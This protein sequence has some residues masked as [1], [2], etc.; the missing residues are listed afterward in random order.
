MAGFCARAEADDY[1]QWGKSALIYLKTSP[2]GANVTG[3][4]RDFP[5]LVRLKAAD[6][7]FSQAR[8]KGQDIRFSASNGK[9][10]AYQIDR[11][12][13]TK[14]LAEVW[15]KLDSVQ[16]NSETQSLT[17]HWGNPAAGDSSDGNAVF[18]SAD[19]F[20]GVW[21]LGGSSGTALR[22][23]SVLGGVDAD[24][25]YFDGGE[26]V[27]GIIGVA[28]SLD[29]DAPYGDNLQFGDGYAELSS[30]FTFSI[31]CNPASTAN[32]SRL[33]DM[34][35]G[36]S[37]DEMVLRRSGTSQSIVYDNYQGNALG[38]STKV[39]NCFPAKQWQQFT[40][41][42]AGGKMNLY[43]NGSLIA[44]DDNPGNAITPVRR[45]YNYMGRND[46][47]AGA[48][49]ESLLDE[50]QLS[51]VA[52]SADW[53]KLAYANQGPTQNLVFFTPPVPPVTCVPSFSMSKDTAL[54]EGSTLV[55]SGS[56][57][58]ATGYNWSAVAGPVPR[59]L[60]PE[61]KALQVFLPRIAHDTS[62]TYRFSASYPDSDHYQDVT[63]TIRADIPDP[64]FTLP[65]TMDWNGV[66]S[67]MIK[68]DISN[69]AAVKAS[70]QPDLHFSWVLGDLAADTAWRDDGLML[71]SASG[72]GDM[73]VNLC[74]DNNGPAT[75]KSMIVS[76]KIPTG[77][78]PRAKAGDA[79]APRAGFD[80]AGRALPPGNPARSKRSGY[81]HRF[82][83]SPFAPSR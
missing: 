49:F 48:Y 34:G 52:R 57:D 47:G 24:P 46:W 63:V 50:P 27:P 35:N 45:A 7:T 38:R 66:D 70:K 62:L 55:L 10:L 56:A 43:R 60:D 11:W 1:S 59:I 51:K 8:G 2:D 82:S 22:K 9:H 19:G 30:G 77:L 69:L 75:C 3:T 31:W 41:T 4:V 73:T 64:V 18:D 65:A 12:D 44:S 53:I 54:S 68:P 6:F 15:V 28:D 83:T 39:D 26:T 5:V 25:L 37:L 76:V 14:A 80:A 58:C 71:K 72:E 29:G 40:V 36:P 42:V 23:N 61:S 17:M 74:L 16:G 78:K 67:L 32:S 33:L 20:V 79:P 13:S 81:A 21:H